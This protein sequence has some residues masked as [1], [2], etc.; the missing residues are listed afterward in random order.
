MGPFFLL[1]L[2]FSP[3]DSLHGGVRHLQGGD[4]LVTHLAAGLA[5]GDEPVQELLLIFDRLDE[6]CQQPA[7]P[8][9]A[10]Y[11]MRFS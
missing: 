3:Q 6:L 9:L 4:S 11:Q 8:E 2:R 5:E 7:E 1:K 10:F